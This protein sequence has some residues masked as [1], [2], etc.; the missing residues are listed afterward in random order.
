MPHGKAPR[1][2]D[3][4]GYIGGPQVTFWSHFDDLT[5]SRPGDGLTVG[6]K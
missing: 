4:T 1:R 2:V 6:G 3:V 5:E